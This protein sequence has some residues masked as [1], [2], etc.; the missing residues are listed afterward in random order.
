[1]KKCHSDGRPRAWSGQG[2]TQSGALGRSGFPP[3]RVGGPPG[4]L[5]SLP[6][7][8]S[9]SPP[10]PPLLPSPPSPAPSLA[11]LIP[12]PF[13]PPDSR[14]LS[15]SATPFLP[16]SQ[17]GQKPWGSVSASLHT[18]PLPSSRQN[19]NQSTSQLCTPPHLRLPSCPHPGRPDFFMH[20]NSGE[21]PLLGVSV[22]ELTKKHIC[23]LEKITRSGTQHHQNQRTAGDF[24]ARAP[25]ENGGCSLNLG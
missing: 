6:P 19:G 11:L 23:C 4:L 18:P 20:V 3:G 9:P 13:L 5:P 7:P 14:S 10:P 16:L 25:G 12:P 24:Q 17:L 21:S 15:H 8:S 1:M 22:L 2:V